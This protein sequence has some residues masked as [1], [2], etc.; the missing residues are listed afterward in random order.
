[1]CFLDATGSTKDVDYGA[2]KIKQ[3]IAKVNPKNVILMCYDK[4]VALKNTAK[5]ISEEWPHIQWQHCAF[6][7]LNLLLKDCGK[8][9]W[10]K[11]VVDKT[12]DIVKYIQA[13]QCHMVVFPI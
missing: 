3:Y 8:Q 7:C 6:F 10:V 5:K 11:D 2:T 1:M 12:N 9:Q 13:H 4:V